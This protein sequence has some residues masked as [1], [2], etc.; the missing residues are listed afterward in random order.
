MYGM[1]RRSTDLTQEPILKSAHEYQ[2]N[3]FNN[4]ELSVSDPTH[5]LFPLTIGPIVPHVQT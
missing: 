4:N 2:N 1:S 5:S 3:G